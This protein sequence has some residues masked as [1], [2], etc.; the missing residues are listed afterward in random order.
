MQH[1][2]I[3]QRRA[4]RGRQQREASQPSAKPPAVR[5]RETPRERPAP[6]DLVTHHG[7]PGV[8]LNAMGVTRDPIAARP[9]PQ[10]ETGR[11]KAR[12]KA[13]LRLCR[14][15]PNQPP[16][17]RQEGRKGVSGGG[18][19]R[20]GRKTRHRAAQRASARETNGQ[21]V[22]TGKARQIGDDSRRQRA[23]QAGQDAPT[24]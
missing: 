12:R 6:S 2:K 18:A 4:G 24:C 8:S 21:A 14:D 7:K 1:R 15:S 20:K 23:T 17:G 16:E 5:A 9:A 11:E 13:G 3:G 22:L 10:A 19:T